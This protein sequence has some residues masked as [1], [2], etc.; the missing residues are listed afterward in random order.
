MCVHILCMVIHSYD[1]SVRD[2]F[3]AVHFIVSYKLQQLCVWYSDAYG[4]TLYDVMRSVFMHMHLGTI[5]RLYLAL[6]GSEQNYEQ[7]QAWWSTST[8]TSVNMS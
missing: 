7:S 4:R 5:F 6:R 1:D 8:G 2:V 3:M